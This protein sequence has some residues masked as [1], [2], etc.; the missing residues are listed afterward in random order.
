ML[1]DKFKSNISIEGNCL[2]N[3]IKKNQGKCFCVQKGKT[4][5]IK[6]TGNH[7][8]INEQLTPGS[9]KLFNTVGAK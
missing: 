2:S 6:Y 5:E 9:R 3:F 8:F 7:I 1:N 4:P